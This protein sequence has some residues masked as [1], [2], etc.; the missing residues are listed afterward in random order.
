MKVFVVKGGKTYLNFLPN[1]TLVKKLENADVIIFA[2]GPDVNPKL[3]NAQWENTTR[4]DSARDTSDK[5]VFDNIPKNKI[6]VGFGRGGQFLTVM[7]GGKLI[8][9]CLWMDDHFAS[10]DLY[11]EHPDGTFVCPKIQMHH[12]ALYP[13][14]CE[15]YR[16]I[17]YTKA[18]RFFSE[19]NRDINYQYNYEFGNPEIVVYNNPDK[20]KCIAVQF[21]PTVYEEDLLNYPLKIIEEL[22]NESLNK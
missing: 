13:W 3:Y 2:D 7:N 1:A 21:L 11:I 19:K 15:K 18:I 5:L 22:I 6:V 9:D 8:Q 20:P 17:A 14:N 10:H 4:Y 16:V 12:Q